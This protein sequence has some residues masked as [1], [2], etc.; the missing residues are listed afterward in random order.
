MPGY[1]LLEYIEKAEG[2]M[3]MYTW[4]EIR[5]EQDQRTNLFRGLS[6]IM[7]SLSRVP[8]PRI[9]SFTLNDEGVLSLTN[10]PLTYALHE[11]ENEGV[12]TGIARNQTYTST[13]QYVLD[14]LAYHEN[15]LRYRPNSIHDET[16]CMGQMAALTGMRAVLP[17]FVDRNLRNG[18]FQLTLTDLHPPNIYVAHQW[19]IKYLIDLEWA[20][21]LPIEMQSPPH[22][23]NNRGIDQLEDNDYQDYDVL[24]EEFMVAFEIEKRLMHQRIA[25]K[26]HLWRKQTIRE[27]WDKGKF[28]YFH[29][30][31]STKE[32]FNVVNPHN[33][34]RY[35]AT[36][37]AIINFDDTFSPFWN[38]DADQ[39]TAKKIKDKEEYRISLRKFFETTPRVV[40]DSWSTG[41]TSTGK[42]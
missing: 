19:R 20:C 10:R 18:P 21:S 42:K 36:S 16:D 14:T 7:L 40:F 28:F 37:S 30:L 27:V 32:L 22:W 12:P 34:G 3:L 35:S 5:H 4:D 1:L 26:D 23:L 13:E 25:E 31:M 6:R 15:L 9:G 29:A 41:S 11:L 33:L 8:L 24:R 38:T 39:V 17:H 2:E